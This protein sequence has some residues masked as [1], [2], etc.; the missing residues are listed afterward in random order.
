MG[1]VKDKQKMLLQFVNDELPDN[2]TNYI[3]ITGDYVFAT[4]RNI[5]VR[6]KN[7]FDYSELPIIQLNNNLD[8][9]FEYGEHLAYLRKD[10][11]EEFS[12][13]NGLRA[14]IFCPVF[15]GLWAFDIQYLKKIIKLGSR[16]KIYQG[17]A[18]NVYVFENENY[19]ISLCR[20]QT[21]EGEYLHLK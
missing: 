17:K 20:C 21:A 4:D 9:F 16:W 3:Q 14:N 1:K 12:R 2:W 5:L 11:L 8:D 15:I 7:D 18:K 6:T 10:E 19:T 13:K